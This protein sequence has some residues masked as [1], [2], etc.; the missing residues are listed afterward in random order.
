VSVSLRLRLIALSEVCTERPVLSPTKKTK[1]PT[2]D[3]K[4]MSMDSLKDV[5]IDQLLDLHSANN[6]SAKVTAKLREAATDT[7]LKEAL[8]RGEDG[9]K[10]G[11]KVMKSISESHGKQGESEH[12]KGMEGL[13]REAEAHALDETF[14]DDD[15]R[16]AMII[17]QYQRMAH[18]AIAGY[19]CLAAFAN[20]LGLEDERQ[21][22]QE[23][24]DACYSGDKGMSELAEGGIN[25]AAV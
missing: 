5:Y 7:E 14:G 8:Q 20:R 9:I 10:E 21:Q 25:K 11:M 23:C 18:Y 6:Q 2:R 12:C 4:N 16:D 19:G 13:V 24:L 17:T 3:Q 15:T 1:K 22:I